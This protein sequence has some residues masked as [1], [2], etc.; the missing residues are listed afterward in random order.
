MKKYFRDALNAL[1]TAILGSAI[2]LFYIHYIVNGKSYKMLVCG[3]NWNLTNGMGTLAAIRKIGGIRVFD[4][5]M[6]VWTVY[7]VV[8]AVS[9]ILFY[10]I[11]IPLGRKITDKVLSEQPVHPFVSRTVFNCVEAFIMTVLMGLFDALIYYNDLTDF[12][13][14]VF[15]ANWFRNFCLYIPFAVCILVF[16]IQPVA[17]L[18]CKPLK[19]K[20]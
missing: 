11:V 17:R 16:I 5:I 20:E 10:F 13:I 8:F 15:L 2:F 1:V 6:P 19:D 4:K 12:K 9:L 18:I 3:G 14:T 7:L